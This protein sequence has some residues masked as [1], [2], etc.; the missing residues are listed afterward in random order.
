[1]NSQLGAWAVVHVKE[2]QLWFSYSQTSGEQH[3]D[4]I[5]LCARWGVLNL[6]FGIQVLWITLSCLR[7]KACKLYFHFAC[8]TFSFWV[9]ITS[10][11]LSLHGFCKIASLMPFIN[12]SFNE[13]SC[14]VVSSYGLIMVFYHVLWLRWKHHIEDNPSFKS[15]LIIPFFLFT[16]V[17]LKPAIRHPC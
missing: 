12:L 10:Y 2:K 7:R 13:F 6:Y 16:F 3:S 4:K 14:P 15:L 8:W 1:M 17:C 5:S 9:S 11:S